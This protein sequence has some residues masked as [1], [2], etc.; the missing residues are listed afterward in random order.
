[1]AEHRAERISEL[2]KEEFGSILRKDLKDPR[3][4]FVSVTAVEVSNDYSH[5]KI[6]VS[7]LGDETS[8]RSAMEGLESA[9]GFIRTELGKRIR[10]RHTPEVHIIADDSIERGSRIIELIEELKRSEKG[11]KPS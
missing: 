10:L 5:V 7:I 11:E 1:M 6:F 4:G 2:I 8:K 9:K 3:I